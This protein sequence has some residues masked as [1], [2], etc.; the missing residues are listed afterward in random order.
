MTVVGGGTAKSFS[1]EIT[2]LRC[3]LLVVVVVTRNH[4]SWVW[5][6]ELDTPIDILRDPNYPLLWSLFLPRFSAQ[7]VVSVW[8]TGSA[9]SNNK[10]ILKLGQGGIF[11]Y[12]RSSLSIYNL[13]DIIVRSFWIWCYEVLQAFWS[14]L[15]KILNFSHMHDRYDWTRPEALSNDEYLYNYSHISIIKMTLLK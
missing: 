15:K 5:Q 3:S 13:H 9:V 12:H 6:L 14:E 8:T 1:E 4:H 11:I 10:F 7:D 2:A